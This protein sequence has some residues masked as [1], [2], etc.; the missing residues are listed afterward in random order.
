MANIFQS[1]L[2]HLNSVFSKDPKS[3]TAFKLQ[4]PTQAKMVI[5]GRSMRIVAVNTT[6][7]LFELSFS[8]PYDSAKSITIRDL[9]DALRLTQGFN[10]SDLSTALAPLGA[11]ALEDGEYDLQPEFFNNVRAFTSPLWAMFRPVSFALETAR[12]DIDKAI[13]QLGFVSAEGPFLDYWGNIF[14]VPRYQDEPD[15]E[16]STRLLW[17]TIKPRLNNRA[18]EELLRRG[19]GYETQVVDLSEKILLGDGYPN[20]VDKSETLF[21]TDPLMVGDGHIDNTSAGF[22]DDEGR[23]GLG[24]RYTY[25]SFGVY[26]DAPINHAYYR[27]TTEQM[28]DIVERHRAAGTTPFFIITQVARE[29]LDMVSKVVYSLEGDIAQELSAGRVMFFGDNDHQFYGDHWTEDNVAEMPWYQNNLEIPSLGD[30]VVLHSEQVNVP[31]QVDTETEGLFTQGALGD[32]F[33]GSFNRN[34]LHGDSDTALADEFQ[35]RLITTQF[36]IGTGNVEFLY[37]PITL[38]YKRVSDEYTGPRIVE[39]FTDDVMTKTANTIT[40]QVGGWSG[41]GDLTNVAGSTDKVFT[42][43]LQIV[44]PTSISGVKFD[45]IALRQTNTHDLPIVI[46][47]LEIPN[48]G[49]NWKQA[50]GI[51]RRWVLPVQDACGNRYYVEIEWPA[52]IPPPVAALKINN[53]TATITVDFVQIQVGDTVNITWNATNGATANLRQQTIA[54]GAYTDLPVAFSGTDQINGLTQDT[55]FTL[56]ITGNNGQIAEASCIVTIVATRTQ[57]QQ[58]II[59][60]SALPDVINLCEANETLIDYTIDYQSLQTESQ[61]VVFGINAAAIVL[62]PVSGDPAGTTILAPV[63][64]DDGSYKPRQIS[65]SRTGDGLPIQGGWL[66]L[67]TG[68]VAFMPLDASQCWGHSIVF[69]YDVNYGGSTLKF[70]DTTI[71]LPNEG[72]VWHIQQQVKV[73]VPPPP[74]VVVNGVVTTKAEYAVNYSIEADNYATAPVTKVVPVYI[75]AIKK[76]AGD[77]VVQT[78]SPNP[79]KEAIG[80]TINETIPVTITGS[81]FSSNMQIFLKKPVD[82]GNGTVRAMLVEAAIV[83]LDWQNNTATFIAPRFEFGVYPLVVVNL[84]CVGNEVGRDETKTLTYYRNDW[85]DAPIIRDVTPK[86]I[87]LVNGFTSKDVFVT[88]QFFRT[89]ATVSMWTAT[90]PV[91]MTTTL[92]SDRSLKF[93]MNHT[94]PGSY[95]ISITNGDTSVGTSNNKPLRLLAAATTPTI[96]EYGYKAPLHSSGCAYYGTPFTLYWTCTETSYVTFLSSDSRVQADLQSED[97]LGWPSTGSLTVPVFTPGTTITLH[98]INECNNQTQQTVT[99]TEV[100]CERT[101]GIRLVPKPVRLTDRFSYKIHTFRDTIKDATG[102]KSSYDITGESDLVYTQVDTGGNTINALTGIVRSTSPSFDVTDYAD[103]TCISLVN[104]IVTADHNGYSRIQAYWNGFTDTTDVYVELPKPISLDATPDPLTYSNINEQFQLVV[105]ALY[106]D[107]TTKDVTADPGVRYYDYDPNLISVTA[108]GVVTTNAAGSTYIQCSY[109]DGVVDPKTVVYDTISVGK[110]DDCIGFSRFYVEPAYQIAGKAIS[111]RTLALSVTGVHSTN[112]TLMVD[113]AGSASYSYI[114]VSAGTDSIVVSATNPP[115]VS[116][117]ATVVWFDPLN[118]IAAVG[119]T[120]RFTFGDSTGAFKWNGQNPLWTQDVHGLNINDSDVGLDSRDRPVK[121]AIVNQYGI[122]T[123]WEYLAGNGY[124]LGKNPTAQQSIFVGQFAVKTA[125]NMT[126]SIYHDDGYI[127]A[128]GNGVVRVGGDWVGVPSGNVTAYGQLPV[129]AAYNIGT[130]RRRTTVTVYFPKPG[131]YPFEFDWADLGGE[132][133]LGVRVNGSPIA[134]NTLPAS[135]SVIAQPDALGVT[136]SSTGPLVVG[137]TVTITGRLTTAPVDVAVDGTVTVNVQGVNVRTA[138][139]NGT[140]VLNESIQ[141]LWNY[142]TQETIADIKTYRMTIAN[143]SGSITAVATANIIKVP[144]VTIDKFLLYNATDTSSQEVSD[145]TLIVDFATTVGLLWKTSNAVRVVLVDDVENRED[146]LPGAGGRYDTPWSDRT[147]TIRAYAPDG[148]YVEKRLSVTVTDYKH[149]THDW[150]NYGVWYNPGSYWRLY[151]DFLHAEST[152]ELVRLGQTATVTLPTYAWNDY[153]FPFWDYYAHPFLG[154]PYFSNGT[155]DER[156]WARTTTLKEHSDNGFSVDGSRPQLNTESTQYTDNTADYDSRTVSPNTNTFYNFQMNGWW[157]WWWWDDWEFIDRINGDVLNDGT[158]DRTLGWK[159]PYKRYWRN[160]FIWPYHT[161]VNVDPGP[162]V[163]S[164]TADTNRVNAGSP[165]TLSYEIQFA[166]SITGNFVSNKR[167]PLYKTQFTVY[168]DKTTDF[169]L[170][171]TSPTGLTTS[172]TVHV[173]VSPQVM[174]APCAGL[175]M[176]TVE[177]IAVDGVRA[178]A[179][180]LLSVPESDDTHVIEVFGNHFLGD[181]TAIPELVGRVQVVLS[182][183]TGTVN[184]KLDLV[185]IQAVSNTYVRFK[186]HIH[187]YTMAG[188][189]GISIMNDVGISSERGLWQSFNIN[190]IVPKFIMNKPISGNSGSVFELW[191]DEYDSVRDVGMLVRIGNTEVNLIG[192]GSSVSDETFITGLYQKILG[193]D[194]EPAGF[195]D[196]LNRLSTGVVT[197]REAME[198]FFNSSE[199]V[200]SG[201][202]VNL[203]GVGTLVRV[204]IT[205]SVPVGIGLRTGNGLSETQIEFVPVVAPPVVTVVDTCPSITGLSVMSAASGQIVAIYGNNITSDTQVYVGTTL[206]TGTFIGSNEIR[207]TVPATTGSRIVSIALR[208]DACFDSYAGFYIDYPDEILDP[209]FIWVPD[210][211]TGSTV[212]TINGVN[213]INDNTLIGNMTLSE[214]YY[215]EKHG[216]RL[217]GS[218][219]TT[220]SADGTYTQPT[221]EG[222]IDN[223]AVITTVSVNEVPVADPSST[224]ISYAKYDDLS[225]SELEL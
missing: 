52:E 33:M 206:V 119:L 166:S 131:L 65:V 181:R 71:E 69:N 130:M 187:P 79:I 144:A 205:S 193:R 158:F 70:Q 109:V 47:N 58:P 68:E 36:P 93:V 88:G 8:H 44:G 21:G 14:G 99:V 46:R 186:V 114:G 85:R 122:M 23:Y 115:V 2:S 168:P 173:D 18:I 53:P 214:Y 106:S 217:L 97:P 138:I 92:I 87:C 74:T 45:E 29:L 94:T 84:D 202:D 157:F 75:Q 149:F 103:P 151:D 78:V 143:L 116:N 207:F 19:I 196:W 9:Y 7:P 177:L 117:A 102:E 194:P 27:Y 67:D 189:F 62:H 32:G 191:I 50:Y 163:V 89:G 174:Y 104:K 34:L 98:A 154:Y 159:L 17:E 127:M 192:V 56:T 156:G 64:K 137:E 12:N 164:F 129:M 5:A 141:K 121:S 25:G 220:L 219:A 147:Y 59:T 169:V 171:A 100:E 135:S 24:E 176:P 49:Q 201:R 76:G 95:D 161:H 142:Q 107:G 210:Y 146:E 162:R 225:A 57:A 51:T 150:F 170:T 179:V 140:S 175:P 22:P 216:Y 185:E 1:L 66:G 224:Q 77:F 60:A 38:S 90:G 26:V 178:D 160:N 153:S 145:G 183:S 208:K 155:Y 125:G 215:F 148:S 41:L 30:N 10:V 63:R 211:D 28:Q 35:F 128:V 55:K 204:V 213:P 91:S 172:A 199:Y 31:P 152:P 195:A 101:T 86:S 15:Y 111:S 82:D 83:T 96:S 124:Q 73:Q 209:I 113:G 37:R 123:G 120:G 203:T 223:T 42:T 11:I 118:S 43:P 105:I 200:G 132:S 16:Y 72:N 139:L 188:N 190:P 218:S 133:C 6:I 80:N 54:T 39:G 40:T 3:L 134:I 167:L 61:T 112:Q 212:K 184:T 222:S 182:H 180:P 13:K 110:L 126:F 4:P 221:Y 108:V 48:F 198:D 20:P 197:R 165:V 136:L 81:G